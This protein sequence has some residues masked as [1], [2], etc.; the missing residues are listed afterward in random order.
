M[1][2]AQRAR[3]EYLAFRGAEA[4]VYAGSTDPAD[5]PF[6][7]MKVMRVCAEDLLQVE[8]EWQRSPRP[9]FLASARA[10]EITSALVSAREAFA[11][12]VRAVEELRGWKTHKGH[13]GIVVI[14]PPEFKVRRNENFPLALHVQDARGKDE[15]VVLITWKYKPTELS[16]WQFQDRAIAAH[17][18]DFADF[19]LQESR[20]QWLG[21]PGYWFRYRYAW[22]GQDIMA[23]I[24]QNAFGTLPWELR[25]LAVADQFDIE[26]C[27]EIVRSLKREL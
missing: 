14:C 10:Q 18:K 9:P 20:Q 23:L 25:F 2:F 22:E 17:Q 11:K 1:D 4:P 19:Q 27:E 13:N 24:Y 26:E 7:L 16:E 21:V 6:G 8:A 15:R 5:C 3:D 12:A